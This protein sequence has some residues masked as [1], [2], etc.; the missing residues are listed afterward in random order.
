MAEQLPPAES[1]SELADYSRQLLRVG[2][3]P[4][5]VFDENNR[6][7]DR[8]LLRLSAELRQAEALER[9]AVAQEELAAPALETD[10]V[11]PSGHKLYMAKHSDGITVSMIILCPSEPQADMMLEALKK[12]VEPLFEEEG[13]LQHG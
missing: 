4:H 9:I 5:Y 13:G 6:T 1:L 12:A 8:E 2:K 3:P 11:S 7:V 10:L